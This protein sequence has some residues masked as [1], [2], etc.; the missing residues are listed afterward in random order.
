MSLSET[1]IAQEFSHLQS[2]FFN[3]A[4]IGPLPHRAALEGQKAID[5]QSNPVDC[6]YDIWRKLPDQN[7]ERIALLLGVGA[8]HISHHSS[9]SE[10][11]AAVSLGFNF[12]PGDSVVL[13]QGDYPSNILP[14]ML[15]EKR[16]SYTIK[17]IDN[18]VFRDPN[19]LFKK[20]PARTKIVNFS[21]VAFNTGR[22]HDIANIGKMCRERDILFVVDCSQSFGGVSL[23]PEEV[24]VCDIIV[25]ATYK[26]LL[27]P[28][29]HA[30]SYWSTKALS[31]IENTHLSWQ[32]ALSGQNASNLLQYTTDSL[33]GA[34][35][36]D[37]GQ[38][39]QFVNT[40]MFNKS[41]ELLS[42]IGLSAIEE[43]NKSL[44]DYFLENIPAKSFEVL[45]PQGEHKNIICLRQKNTSEAQDLENALR[46][47]QI[48][49][50]VREGN[51]RLSFHLFNTKTEVSALIKVL[52][53]I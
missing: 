46:Q 44:V 8:A 10:V 31:C 36:F 35:R 18:D 29:G 14:W 34:R 23:R 43:R 25:G 41:L 3:T 21:H 42:E 32:S 39:P 7:R 27:G 12:S 45:T 16:Q 17:L 48:E 24:H 22:C 33:P 26:W 47:N 50:S 6:P 53:K 9:V 19:E 1:L 37:R 2:H 13:M 15:N 20:I 51:L 52:E 49:S 30:F 4:Y 11:I 40:R 5:Q 28:Y 38:A